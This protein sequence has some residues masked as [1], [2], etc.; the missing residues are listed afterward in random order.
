MA[1]CASCNGNLG[2]MLDPLKNLKDHNANKRSGEDWECP[3]CG[4]KFS[5]MQGKSIFDLLDDMSDAYD[6]RKIWYD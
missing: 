5:N 6:K 4:A 2:S 1:K 3:H